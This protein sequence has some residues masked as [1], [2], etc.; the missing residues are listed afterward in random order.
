M[1]PAHSHSPT[2]SPRDTPQPT[3]MTT[4]TPSRPATSRVIP[5]HDIALVRRESE[6]WAG[7]SVTA[8]WDAQTFVLTDIIVW[9]PREAGARPHAPRGRTVHFPHQ[10]AAPS[11]TCGPGH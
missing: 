4:H 3:P 9:S 10:A 7:G 8:A 5:H 2:R 6:G 11:V 1:C